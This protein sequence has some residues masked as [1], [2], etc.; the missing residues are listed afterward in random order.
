MRL[1]PSKVNTYSSIRNL[2][3]SFFWNKKNDNGR[4]KVAFSTTLFKVILKLVGLR[5]FL[6]IMKLNTILVLL[7]LYIYIYF[8]PKCYTNVLQQLIYFGYTKA[9]IN[10]SSSIVQ[11]EICL[12]I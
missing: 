3:H 11:N 5:N 4:E 7:I 10:Y 9:T 6:L 12:A 2:S 1:I 8:C